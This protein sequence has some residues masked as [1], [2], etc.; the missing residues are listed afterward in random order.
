MSQCV[1]AGVNTVQNGY[2]SRSSLDF[3]LRMFWAPMIHLPSWLKAGV[4]LRWVTSLFMSLQMSLFLEP[5]L[6]K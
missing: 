1:Q 4:V 6:A 3:R 2:E 5:R